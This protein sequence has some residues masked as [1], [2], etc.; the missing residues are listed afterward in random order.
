M[1]K[2]HTVEGADGASAD[3]TLKVLAGLGRI[4]WAVVRRRL[5]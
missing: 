5:V 2:S 1:A 3:L 4:T